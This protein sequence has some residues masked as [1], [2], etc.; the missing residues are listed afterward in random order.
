MTI[1]VVGLS[2]LGTVTALGFAALGQTVLAVDDDGEA[3][4][5]LRRGSLTVYEPGLDELRAAHGARLTPSTDFAGLAEADL[6]V[7]ARDTPTDAAGVAD[8]AAIDALVARSVLH[9]KAGTVLALMSQTAP[10]YARSVQRRIAAQRPELTFSVYVWVETLIFGQ[11]VERFLHPERIVLG[12][13]DPRAS[14]PSP[15]GHATEDF[16]CPVVVMGYESAELTK[17]AINLYLAASVTCANTLADLAEAVGADWTE[18][19]RALRL[20]V[21]IGPAAYLR[22]GLGIGSNLERDLVALARLGRETGRDVA[23][24]DTVLA[25]SRARYA[26]VV[27]QLRRHVF[28]AQGRPI[29]ALWGLAYKKNTRSVRNSPALRL[30]QALSG[31]ATIRAWDPVVT[32]ADVAGH[33]GVVGSAEEAVEGADALVIM[34]DWDVFAAVDLGNV[35]ARMRR[36]VVIDCVGALAGRRAELAGIT[37]V[38]MGQ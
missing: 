12:A 23:L 35:R 6:V 34:T 28:R 24:I 26:W 13:A 2:H 3:V 38:G 15:L 21:R 30:A 22:P 25:A 37:Y 14:L 31:Y 17:T 19:V 10:G 11:A 27:R 29:L 4:A 32:A 9:L 7:V 5:A 33:A 8:L 36:P 16:G 20:D 18:I 1:A